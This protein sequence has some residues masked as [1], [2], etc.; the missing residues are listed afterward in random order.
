MKNTLWSQTV[1][2][3]HTVP[4]TRKYLLPLIR[5]TAT[6]KLEVRI[7]KDYIALQDIPKDD[8][9]QVYDVYLA[10]IH[11]KNSKKS[12]QAAMTFAKE[13]E[14]KLTQMSLSTA[15]TEVNKHLES[16]GLKKLSWDYKAYPD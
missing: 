12:I 13:N 6:A 8:D 16:L 4:E 15:V 5:K 9:G 3:A 1:K 11:S 10:S 14:H 2:L 7:K